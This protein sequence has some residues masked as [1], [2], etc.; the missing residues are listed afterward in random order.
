MRE[1]EVCHYWGAGGYG[2]GPLSL[3]SDGLS[4]A[5]WRSTGRFGAEV[6]VFEREL[7]LMGWRMTATLRGVLC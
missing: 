3:L 5:A 6:G 4:G 2:Q 1:H 7:F